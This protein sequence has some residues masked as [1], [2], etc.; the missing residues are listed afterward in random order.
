MVC[1]MFAYTLHIFLIVHL[2]HK[3]FPVAVLFDSSTL[4]VV[5]QVSGPDSTAESPL[6]YWRQREDGGKFNAVAVCQ[7]ERVS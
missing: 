2:L 1:F 5:T 4:C 3:I 6:C 7:K